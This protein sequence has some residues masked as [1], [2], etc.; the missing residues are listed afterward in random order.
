MHN[1]QTQNRPKREV[2]HAKEL[3]DLKKENHTLKRAVKRLQKE[4]SKRVDI[5][6]D[7]AEQGLEEEQT[8]TLPKASE[9]CRAPLKYLELNGKTWAICPECKARNKVP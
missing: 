1:N 7:A 4:I 3:A 2:A 5:E 6:E 8:E 9:C